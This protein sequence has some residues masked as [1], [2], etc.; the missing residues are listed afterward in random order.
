MTLAQVRRYGPKV[1]NLSCVILKPH[2]GQRGVC[3]RCLHANIA[4][5]G[6]VNG[7]A[8]R[9]TKMGWETRGSGTYYYRKVRSGGRV[10]SEY[11]GAGFVAE[12][13]AELDA[14][15]RQAAAVQR[16]AWRAEAEAER[17]TAATL[18]EVDRMVQ[19]MTAAAL[20]AAGYHTHRRQWRRQRGAR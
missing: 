6:M 18:A 20:I 7:V 16:Q 8:Q 4:E 11:I 19:T 17:R 14:R 1:Y 2:L 13:L 12:A 9:C 10:R 5:R 15:G 3:H